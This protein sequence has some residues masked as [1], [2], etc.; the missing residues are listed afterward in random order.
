[1]KKLV[2]LGLA[3]IM[4][5]F[6]GCSGEEEEEEHLIVSQEEAVVTY[7]LAA[8]EKGDVEKT[9]KIYVTY[10]QLNEENLSFPV[11]A[12]QVSKVYVSEGDTVEEGDLLAELSGSSL[13]TQIEELEYRIERNELSLKSLKSSRDYELEAARLNYEYGTEKSDSDKS[14]YNAQKEQIKSSYEY[15]IE[16]LSDSIELDKMQLEI[17]REDLSNSR[18]IAGMS[19]TVS[20]VKKGLS[21]ST[22]I[23]DETVITV[24]DG[25]ECLFSAPDIKYAPFFYEGQEI[26][27]NINVGSAAGDYTVTPFEIETWED[28]IQFVIAESEETPSIQVGTN[29]S[30]YVTTDRAKD[31]L[32]VPNRAVHKADDKSYVYVLT[33]ENLRAVKWVSTGLEGDEYTE[34]TE[35]LTEGETVVLK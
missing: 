28:E 32:Y 15:R 20:F 17:Y 4:L 18:L 33:D 34:I 25:S 24:I 6:A 13:E 14:A 27:L 8:V 16:D 1:M 10:K 23:K 19:G 35:G 9:A 12:K 30:I 5:L 26:A 29:G 2:L 22:S 11:S 31:V 21:G 3:A 7:K